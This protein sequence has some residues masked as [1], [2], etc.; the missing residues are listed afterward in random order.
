M[1]NNQKRR[2]R[3]GL[4]PNEL[5]WKQR[6][7]QQ[8]QEQDG[9]F[10]NTVQSDKVLHRNKDA[11]RQSA[12][13]A[14]EEKMNRGA[15]LNPGNKKIRLNKREQMDHNRRI[16]EGLSVRNMLLRQERRLGI[17]GALSYEDLRRAERS[18]T[19]VGKTN[20]LKAKKTKFKG[21]G[22]TT[23][24][25]KNREKLLPSERRRRLSRTKIERNRKLY[26]DRISTKE[27]VITGPNGEKIN[28]T[29]LRKLRGLEDRKKT[30]KREEASS[31]RT[32]KA[33]RVK[34]AKLQIRRRDQNTR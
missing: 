25:R 31:R 5:G 4:S 11:A 3:L 10:D 14:H 20:P 13:N 26:R 22:K 6:P 34:N 24:K 8:V 19:L 1:E 12:S 7:N 15:A 23:R 27:L 30:A 17:E 9:V 21:V 33:E 18:P 16:R 28:L 29:H 2:I 32:M